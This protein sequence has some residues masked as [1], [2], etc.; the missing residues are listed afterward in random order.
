MTPSIHE[1]CIMQG[2]NTYQPTHILDN[3]SDYGTEPG[4]QHNNPNVQ[5]QSHFTYDNKNDDKGNVTKPKEVSSKTD[6]VEVII[7]MVRQ[8]LKD[9]SSGG[10]TQDAD[11]KKIMDVI[12]PD[13]KYHSDNNGK[14]PPYI[15]KDNPYDTK[16]TGR[17]RKKA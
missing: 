9:R 12:P 14:I 2:N 1:P 16:S 5:G 6:P 11:L 8:L 3:N 4:T 13:S 10:N 7:D 15:G 17:G